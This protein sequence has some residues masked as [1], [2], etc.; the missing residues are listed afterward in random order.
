MVEHLVPTEAREL[1]TSQPALQAL[2]G[3]AVAPAEVAS[4]E[5]LPVGV[6]APVG[7][8]TVAESPN[9]VPTTP[10]GGSWLVTTVEVGTLPK[11][12][13]LELTF[14]ALSVTACWQLAPVPG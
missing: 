1:F 9:L 8:E 4:A 13:P 12:L 11:S 3:V 14:V 2:E 5:D 7:P 10:D 6:G